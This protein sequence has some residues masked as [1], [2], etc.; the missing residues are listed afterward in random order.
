MNVDSSIQHLCAKASGVIDEDSLQ[1]ACNILV[2]DITESIENEDASLLHALLN[3]ITENPS[4]LKVAS[5]HLTWNLAETLLTALEKTTLKELTSQVLEAFCEIGNPK[6]LFSLLMEKMDHTCFPSKNVLLRCLTKVSVRL[7]AKVLPLFLATGLPSIFRNARESVA[8][9]RDSK[10]ECDPE[11]AIVSETLR[12]LHDVSVFTS[13]NVS[14]S[15]HVRKPMGPLSVALL[16]LRYGSV[17]FLPFFTPQHAVRVP[18]DEVIGRHVADS[19]R[20]LYSQ[21]KTHVAEDF[22]IWELNMLVRCSSLCGLTW[23][24]ATTFD[25]NVPEEIRV[26]FEDFFTTFN[27]DLFRL[28]QAIWVCWISFGISSKNLDNEESGEPHVLPHV[29]SPAGLLRAILPSLSVLCDNSVAGV[30]GSYPAEGAPSRSFFA[31]CMLIS[32]LAERIHKETWVR[33]F[34]DCHVAVRKSHCTDV[35]AGENLYSTELPFLVKKILNTSTTLSSDFYRVLCATCA[36]CLFKS[37]THERRA[38]LMHAVLIGTDDQKV[39]GFIANLLKEEVISSMSF[40]DE[41]C[42]SCGRKAR[43]GPT[44]E[45]HRVWTCSV[46]VV[47]KESDRLSVTSYIQACSGDSTDINADESHP[48]DSSRPSYVS[49]WETLKSLSDWRTGFFPVNAGCPFSIPF[50]LTLLSHCLFLPPLSPPPEPYAPLSRGDFLESPETMDLF[51]SDNLLRKESSIWREMSLDGV[52]LNLFERSDALVT[53]ANLLR[54]LILKKDALNGFPLHSDTC[55]QRR[56]ELV[57]W[58]QRCFFVPLLRALSEAQCEGDRLSATAPGKNGN[59]ASSPD[60]GV[61]DVAD[62][63]VGSGGAN[64]GVGRSFKE[65]ACGAVPG[66]HGLGVGGARGKSSAGNVL[67]QGLAQTAAWV[68]DALLVKTV[69]SDVLSHARAALEEHDS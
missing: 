29:Y 16:L 26:K 63:D 33:G 17:C 59:P 21:L 30:V 15:E 7:P 54:L 66:A 37:V 38:A 60:V 35:W 67:G 13:T 52:L 34:S 58:V 20:R 45:D 25:A 65:G 41:F 8:R 10:C 6:E 64:T 19:L 32:M 69:L 2:V 31:S 36:L 9:V 12:F 48:H 51:S 56:H 5:S 50:C 28:G 61:A 11:K 53:G 22:A 39:R 1:E 40:Q 4:V 68:T 62:D 23:Q 43:F 14:Y 42:G 44:S 49:D 3:T 55:P 57:S 47:I 18:S 27:D 24:A 46:D